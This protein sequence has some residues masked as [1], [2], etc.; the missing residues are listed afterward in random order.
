VERKYVIIQR[1]PDGNTLIGIDCENRSAIN[2]YLFQDEKHQKKFRTIASV[3]LER[4]HNR[5][6]YK[7][8]KLDDKINNVWAM[9]FFVKAENDRIYCQEKFA[10]GKKICVMSV[11]HLHKT[12]MGNSAREIAAI[13]LVSG[14]VYSE[15][16]K[17]NNTENVK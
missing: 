13:T 14:Y 4:L 8:E 15:T 2:A 11:L 1:S 17:C 10:G 5:Q 12:S 6:L 9:R 3:I 16:T 7:W